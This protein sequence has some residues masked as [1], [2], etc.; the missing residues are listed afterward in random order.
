MARWM[1]YANLLSP[2][3]HDIDLS[4]EVQFEGNGFQNVRPDILGILFL[5][6]VMYGF[7]V[8]R[9][10]R[11][12]RWRVGRRLPLAI[13]H[14]FASLIGCEQQQCEGQGHQPGGQRERS[15]PKDLLPNRGVHDG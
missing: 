13:C 14:G 12:L 2:R 3:R 10:R 1:R 11:V 8:E 7:T 9:C 5:R 15:R 6:S 4:H